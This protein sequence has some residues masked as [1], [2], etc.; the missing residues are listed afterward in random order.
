MKKFR[1]FLLW[2]AIALVIQNGVFLYFEK[3]YLGGDTT[4]K[5]EKVEKKKVSNMKDINIPSDAKDIK[6]SHNGTY[7]AFMED[8]VLKVGDRTKGDIK[9]VKVEENME[10]NYAKWVTDG[11]FLIIAEKTKSSKSKPYIDIHKYDVS[12]DEKVELTDLDLKKD[13]INLSS[14]KDN[15]EDMAF[16]TSSN[17]MYFKIGKSSNRSDIYKI[18]VMSQLEKVKTNLVGIGAIDIDPVNANLL[19]EQTNMVKLNT[20]TKQTKIKNLSEGIILGHNDN[21]VF[22]GK[23]KSDEIQEIIYGDADKAVSTWEKIK[24]DNKVSKKDIFIT[25]GGR[26]FI[27]DSNKTLTDAVTKK[28][29]KYE[30]TLLDVNDKGILCSVDGQ[31][32]VIEIE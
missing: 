26:V 15:V 19:Y 18:N 1:V 27:K 23:G 24:L 8:G 5:A 25:A 21:S 14:S 22:I 3:V 13:I 28:T 20:G 17:V 16:A 32:K 6:M 9:T 11:D 29:I 4:V 12:R 30:G 10:V 7:I 2:T 31:S